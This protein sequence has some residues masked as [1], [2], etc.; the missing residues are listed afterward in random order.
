MEAIQNP[1]QSQS[2]YPYADLTIECPSRSDRLTAFFRIFCAIPICILLALIVGFASEE[3][4]AVIGGGLL[5]LPLLLSIL[6]RNKY[7]KAWFDWIFY[8]SKFAA[9]VCS[10]IFLLRHEYP[11]I[12]DDQSVKLELRYPNVREELHR[13]MPL[14][15]WF[16]A[17]PH[18]FVLLFLLIAV[19]FVSIFAWFAILFTGRYPAGPHSFVVGVFR[20]GLRVNAYAFLLLTDKY[21][22][23]TLKR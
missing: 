2:S 9:R 23:F 14:V 18:Y 1:N 15:K 5:F 21:P 6:F 3:G 10:Y 13:G 4:A 12:E 16:L 11:S 20:W 22:P 19:L 7:P 17:I 8:L